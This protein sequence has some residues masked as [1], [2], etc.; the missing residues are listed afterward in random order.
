MN[1]VI[2]I[3]NLTRDIELKYTPKGTAVGSVGIAV[4]RKWTTESGE[5]KEE[6]T[7]VDCEAWGRT[8]EVIGEYAKKGDKIMFEGRLKL[9]EWDDKETGK[10]RSKIKVVIEN[11]ELLGNKRSEKSRDPEYTGEEPQQPAGRSPQRATRPPRDPD[12]DAAPD[13]IPF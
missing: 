5:K 11:M 9:D 13:D 7:F 12:L 6:V 8:A 3:G 10:K 4:N 2:L 1:K